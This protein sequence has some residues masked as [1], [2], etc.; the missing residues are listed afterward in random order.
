MSRTVHGLPKHWL[1]VC[2]P[3]FRVC[4][5]VYDT[6]DVCRARAMALEG[7][8]QFIAE[9]KEALALAGASGVALSA[10][11]HRQLSDINY[12]KQVGGAWIRFHE[13]HCLTTSPSMSGQCRVL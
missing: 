8:D 3:T 5:T 6:I 2:M 9:G 10:N 4:V 11:D 13:R 12:M 7:H 1:A